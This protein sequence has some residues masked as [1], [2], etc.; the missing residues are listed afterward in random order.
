MAF[1]MEIDSRRAIGKVNPNIYGYFMEHMSRCIYGGIYDE[2]SDLSDEN[3][4][5][6]DVMVAL[7]DIKPPIIRWPGG[8]FASAYHWK[9]GIG[10]KEGRAATYDPVWQVK[11]SNLF[12]T[13]EFIQFCQRIGAKPYIC[14]NMGT[15]TIDEAIEW[16]EYCNRKDTYYAKLR[17]KYGNKEPYGVK[18]WGLGNEIYGEWQIGHK[19][20]VDYAKAAKEFAKTIKGR[21]PDP[22]IKLIATGADDPDWNYE[23][24]KQVGKYIDYICIHGYYSHLSRDY[25]TAMA[26]SQVVE[27]RTRV[28]KGVINAG[29]N[30][31]NNEI[32]IAWDEW[33][34]LD[35]LHYRETAPDED[36]RENDNNKYYN[37]Q[38]ALVTASVLNS[39]QRM[40]KVVTMANYSPA[41]N[42]R[43]VIF[44]Y[45]KGIV[46]R[47]QYHVFKM[48]TSHSGEIALDALIESEEYKCD[49]DKEKVKVKY[50]DVSVTWDK[51][52]QKLFI[53][54]INKHKDKG[55]DCEIKLR[56]FPLLGAV[57]IYQLIHSDILAY[58]DVDRPHEIAITEKSI[59]NL[60]KKPI[61][62]LPAHS[63][64]IIEVDV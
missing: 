23:V 24:I 55:I 40:C 63:I 34:F 61:V 1:K 51:H 47:P 15:G 37:L 13:D 12:G 52:R 28:L 56:N 64:N 3:G 2:Q 16:V 17:E 8:N 4:F 44:V 32:K 36:P 9:N 49:V 54:A 57:Q 46:L 59:E 22:N 41:T 60:S 7:K 19:S 25:Y 35:W 10:P 6:E 39:F 42:M 50:L 53:A 33:N 26:V 62:R 38:N 43:G 21:R 29:M 45:D 30:S 18:Y 20:A 31:V 27:N 11:E 48:Y 5:R 58:N 14:L